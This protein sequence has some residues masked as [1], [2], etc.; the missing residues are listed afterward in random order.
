[1]RV[2]VVIPTY[3]RAGLIGASLDSL[4]AQTH[5]DWDAIVVDDGST[6]DTAAVVAGYGSRVRYVRQ[7]NRGVGA[8]RN[9]GLRLATG[10]LVAFL[11]SDDLWHPY[12]LALQVAVCERLPEIGYLFTEFVI[13]RDDG[14]LLDRGT[15]RWM[16]QR[17]ELASLFAHRASAASLGIAIDGVP[18]FPVYHGPLYRALLDDLPV[19]TSSMIVRRSV[20]DATTHFAEGVAI[21]EDWEFF[22]RLARKAPVAFA[23]VVTTINRGHA[24]PERVTKCS[25]LAKAECYVSLL[26]RVWLADAA[27]GSEHGAVLREVENRA[28][29]AVA[30]EAV[31]AGDAAGALRALARRRRLGTDGGGWGP[32]YGLCARLPGGGLLLRVL[33]AGRRTLQRLSGRPGHAYH[34]VN[35]SV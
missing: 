3:N 22:A 15:H 17:A 20:V 28:L 19:L 10:D 16:G 21:F 18:D 4:V 27:F 5:Q 25:R 34:P 9:T 29:L 35:P 33:L 11:D 2:T 30:R 8:A 26:D 32:I 14:S 1:L 23:D 7:E 24:G 6:D 13:L 12:K 31:L